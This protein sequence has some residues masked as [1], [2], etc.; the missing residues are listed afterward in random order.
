LAKFSDFGLEQL[1]RPISGLAENVIRDAMPSARRLGI[2]LILWGLFVVAGFGASSARAESRAKVKETESRRERANKRSDKATNGCRLQR[3]QSFLKR[4]TF[5]KGGMLQGRRH[6]RALRYRVEHYGHVEGLG[7]ESLNSQTAFSQAESVR[8]L[9]LPLSVHKKIVPALRCVERRIAKVCKKADSRYTPQAVGGFRQG[10][11]YRGGEVSNHLFGIAIDIDPDR[12]PCCGCVK[13]W[14]E[15]P[16]CKDPERS[17]YEKT[18]L[19]RC[20]IRAFERY[21]FYWLG[22]DELEDT[23]HFEYLGDPDRIEP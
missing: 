15:H 13:P 4:P 22:R 9:G 20:W 21:G 6:Q 14:P 1:P 10:N 5:I 11:T 23:M 7:L 17:I 12:N 3:A 8:F 19:P 16:L 18:S 2:V